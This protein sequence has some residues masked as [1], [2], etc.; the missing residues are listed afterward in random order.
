[1]NK[2]RYYWLTVLLTVFMML[3]FT[4]LVFAEND[5]SSNLL[6]NLGAESKINS[7][8]YVWT[9]ELNSK[10]RMGTNLSF[11]LYG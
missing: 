1:V 11:T 2:D 6:V 10:G 3:T 9:G 4:R 7:E 5:W 8:W